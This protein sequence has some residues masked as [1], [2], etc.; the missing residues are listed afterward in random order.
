MP[1][2]QEPIPAATNPKK[3]PRRRW[4]FQY[5]VRTLLIFVTVVGVLCGWLGMFLQRVRHQR[6]VMAQIEALG[7]GI[8]G[9]VFL[10]NAEWVWFTREYPVKDKEL[11][12]S[13]R[14][15]PQL[16]EV[17]LKGPGI[18]DEWLKYFVDLPNLEHL[19]LNNTNITGEGLGQLEKNK[20]LR[21]LSLSGATVNDSTLKIIEN[22]ANLRILYIDQTSVTDDGMIYL[23]R[24][25]R[26]RYLEFF[27]NKGI[28]DVGALGE[29]KNLEVF[30]C[31]SE[32]VIKADFN[33]MKRLTQLKRIYVQKGLERSEL[34]E[35]RK[36]IRNILPTCTVDAAYNEDSTEQEQIESFEKD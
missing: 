8:E 27:S 6:I 18:T 23:A 24:L 30:H 10:S 22:L 13:F 26:L 17:V 31:D 1:D 12:S 21:L 15:L 4:R 3:E 19:F 16:K 9:T 36:I 35:L 11:F 7:G 14:E 34:L 20:K 32:L 2:A 25:S 28:T 5:S 33:N 29:L